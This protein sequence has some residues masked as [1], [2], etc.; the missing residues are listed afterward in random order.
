M[1]KLTNLKRQH[2]T[3]MDSYLQTSPFGAFVNPLQDISTPCNYQMTLFCLPANYLMSNRINCKWCHKIKL[4]RNKPTPTDLLQWLAI[5]I[6]QGLT[7]SSEQQNQPILKR[8]K[9]QAMW[10]VSNWTEFEDAGFPPV[11]IVPSDSPE[12]LSLKTPL[13]LDYKADMEACMSHPASM[14]NQ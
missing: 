6:V 10:D 13:L 5:Y 9:Q 14:Y 11:Q 8:T 4:R 1:E 7:D 2:W 12:V 3:L